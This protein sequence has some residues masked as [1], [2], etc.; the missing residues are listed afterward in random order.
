MAMKTLTVDFEDVLFRET[1]TQTNGVI[2][3]SMEVLVNGS[4]YSL[5]FIKKN[6]ADQEILNI[7]LYDSSEIPV[8]DIRVHYA[9]QT[10]AVEDTHPETA[11]ILL[12]SGTDLKVTSETLGLDLVVAIH[13]ETQLEPAPVES[14]AAGIAMRML[15][16]ERQRLK[17]AVPR[18][19]CPEEELVLAYAWK[20]L[21]PEDEQ[22]IGAHVHKCMDC[23]DMVIAA[24]HAVMSE[25]APVP[26]PI[27]LTGNAPSPPSEFEKA[28]RWP[29]SSVNDM[30]QDIRKRLGDILR[31]P[32]AV[33]KNALDFDGALLAASFYRKP[34]Q[35]ADNTDQ[36]V[37]AKWILFE[38]NAITEVRPI[39]VQIHHQK[40]QGNQLTLSGELPSVLKQVKADLRFGW[41]TSDDLI[42]LKV[43]KEENRNGF[44]FRLLV[45]ERELDP[46]GELKMLIL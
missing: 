2:S 14:S 12:T 4:P 25:G 34:M 30:I 20:E 39:T 17:T 10:Y 16:A 19:D 18:D 24:R 26:L 21:S 28:A 9:G 22:R 6:V 13:L 23:L 27:W 15:N 43:E 37:V 33:T 36:V 42:S 40:V 1:G 8:Q 41:I 29:Y 5:R 3:R 31:W 45:A 35:A 11:A 44:F 46:D 7:G 38:N 32:V